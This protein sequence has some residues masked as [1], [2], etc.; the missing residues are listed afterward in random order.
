MQKH[1]LHMTDIHRFISSDCLHSILLDKLLAAIYTVSYV[2]TFGLMS[3]VERWQDQH[4]GVVIVIVGGWCS[5]GFGAC[6]SS[7]SNELI[8]G[9]KTGKSDLS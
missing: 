5:K 4:D 9:I 7:P 8:G 6:S 3:S 2:A 1:K